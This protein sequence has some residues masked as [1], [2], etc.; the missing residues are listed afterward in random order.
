MSERSGTK[1]CACQIH[2]SPRFRLSSSFRPT[3]SLTVGLLP[4]AFG[5]QN[6]GNHAASGRQTSN[7]RG[8]FEDTDSGRTRASLRAGG[9]ARA[10]VALVPWAS[11][12]GSPT[13]RRGLR[14][15][16]AAAGRRGR[17]REQARRRPGRG[18][19]RGEQVGL[20]AS[21]GS[22]PRPPREAPPR[23]AP[24]GARR[25][26]AAQGSRS[27]SRALGDSLKITVARGATAN[28]PRVD[29]TLRVPA[30]ARLKVYTSDGA[31]EVLGVPA[32]L[33]RADAL[34]RPAAR[35]A[36]AARRDAHRAVAQRL[37]LTS[38]TASRRAARARAAREVSDALGAGGPPSTSSPG[39]AASASTR[40]RATRRFDRRESAARRAARA[41]Q[42]FAPRARRR[43]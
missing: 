24:R 15:P 17:G 2:R 12:R 16:R 10:V 1:P 9:A 29:L 11:R 20:A 22:R 14:E 13:R 38:A 5:V 32:S 41:Q 37:R 33:D 40:S 34:G 39:A 8:F 43:A 26:P 25:P 31:V 19:G 7:R 3:P 18:L 23:S 6:G 42:H 4:G 28:A 36:R 30:D 35:A 27:T 21:V